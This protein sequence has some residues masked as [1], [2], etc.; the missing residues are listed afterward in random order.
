[1]RT[2][3][4]YR[5]ASNVEDGLAEL[6]R[7][8]SEQARRGATAM[9]NVGELADGRLL[10]PVTGFSRQ[11]LPLIHDHPNGMLHVLSKAGTSSIS[12]YL[13]LSD[14]ARGRI[15]HVASINPQPIIDLTEGETPRLRDRLVALRHL[16]EAGYRIRVRIDPIFDLRHLDGSGSDAFGV[17]RDMVDEVREYCAPEMVTLGSYRPSPGLIPHLR[18]RYP[19]SPVWR[20]E[21][22]RAWPKRRLEGR[23]TFY[24]RIAGWVKKRF[25]SAVVA[26]CKESREAWKAAGLSPA[27]LQCSCLPLY[28][29][30]R[31]AQDGRKSG[32]RTRV[33]RVANGISPLSRA[34]GAVQGGSAQVLVRGHP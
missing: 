34:S 7:T 8:L 17:Y 6:E 30:R 26:L 3:P 11:L 27:P 12:N 2:I 13:E 18:R 24:A 19:G 1:M 14:L 33:P 21:T 31:Q 32:A 23:E 9:F 20:I 29:E 15:I 22:E 28:A 10:D 4:Y 16:G 5:V 25:P